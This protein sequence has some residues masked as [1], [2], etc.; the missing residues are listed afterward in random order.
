MKS[1]D[2]IDIYLVVLKASKIDKC[3][4]SKEH[5]E[6]L[7]KDLEKYELFIDI[8]KKYK[9]FELIKWENEERYA[10]DTYSGLEYI[11]KEESELLEN[12]IDNIRIVK[13]NETVL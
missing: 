9:L 13:N 6:M 11:T 10:I 12:F 5:L 7:Q 3:Y 8:I 1:L 4:I 2:M